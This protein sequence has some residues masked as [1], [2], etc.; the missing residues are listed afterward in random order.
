[1]QHGKL[2]FY[3]DDSVE[4]LVVMHFIYLSLISRD[5]GLNSGKAEVMLEI[6]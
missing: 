6:K 4:E 5:I 1:M 3:L 2:Y